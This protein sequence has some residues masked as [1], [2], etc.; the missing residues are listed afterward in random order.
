MA[1][2][3]DRLLHTL[4]AVSQVCVV[5]RAPKISK[6]HTGTQQGSQVPAAED[7][8]E[9]PLGAPWSLTSHHL[10]HITLSCSC[11]PIQLFKD[12]TRKRKHQKVAL[13]PPMVKSLHS[14]LS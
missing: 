4:H 14:S 2:S 11:S 9:Q 12:K 5:L 7:R 8:R 13:V 10:L 6:T 1:A 3:T